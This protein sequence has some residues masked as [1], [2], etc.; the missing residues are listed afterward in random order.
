LDDEP[1]A[2]PGVAIQLEEHG[3]VSQF[4]QGKDLVDHSRD[5]DT[6]LTNVQANLEQYKTFLGDQKLA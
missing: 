1:A 3:L 6:A 2:L 5:F 4:G